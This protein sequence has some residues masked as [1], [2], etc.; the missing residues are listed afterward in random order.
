[1]SRKILHLTIKKQYFDLIVSGKKKIE[2]RHVKPYWTKRFVLKRGYRFY[3][4]IHIRNGYNRS[5]PF[6]KVVFK[7]IYE[8]IIGSKKCYCIRLGKIL[9]IEN[10]K[11]MGKIRKVK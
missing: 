8:D 11:F 3:D 7:G 10:Y 4:E 6:M 9:N 2:Y 5:S 1:M